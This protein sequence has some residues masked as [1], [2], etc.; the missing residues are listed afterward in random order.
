[1]LNFIIGRENID[2]GPVHMDS[3]LYFRKANP[4]WLNDDFARRAILAID[5]AKVLNGFALESR[6]GYGMSCQQIST[7]TKTLLLI[8]NQPEFI[9]YASNMGDKLWLVLYQ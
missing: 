9:Y 5:K 1:M 6:F 8:K 4:D 3:K 7:G 2:L